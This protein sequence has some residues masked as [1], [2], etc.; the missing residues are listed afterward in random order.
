MKKVSILLIATVF[1]LFITSCG[2][3]KIKSNVSQMEKCLG[4]NKT[5]ADLNKLSK[6]EA[7]AIAK[8]MLEPMENLKNEGDKLSSDDQKKFENELRDALNKSEFKDILINLNY[9][10]IK[11]LAS[12]VPENSSSSSSNSNSTSSSP[13]ASS[14]A[15][16]SDCDKF[17]AN[18][19]EFVT[20]YVEVLKKYKAN[21]TDATILSEYSELSQKAAEMSKQSK[22]CT[23]S[24]YSLKLLEL[25]QK[26]TK[27]MIGH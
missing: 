21:P 8:C 11:R 10:K 22:D 19:E 18:Y 24:K 15:N 27:A 25:S 26:I 13:S 16:A 20:S 3:G 4:S 7:S 14:D 5:T 2:G 12:L 9:D 17:I 23:D 1:T 6:N